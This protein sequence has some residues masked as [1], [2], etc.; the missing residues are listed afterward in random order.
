MGK[1]GLVIQILRDANNFLAR[2]NPLIRITA[3]KSA[4][5]IAVTDQ[6]RDWLSPRDQQKTTIMPAIGIGTSEAPE[7]S[8]HR[9]RPTDPVR[10]LYVGNLLYWKG[11]QLALPAVA[12]VIRQRPDVNITFTV[13]GDGSFRGRLE[14]LA[15]ELD[16]SSRVEFLGKVPR[17]RVL[18]LYASH[19][20]FLFPSLQDSGGVAVVE[21][22][23]SAMPVICLN[24]GGPA[25]SVSSDAGCRVHPT[26]PDE[27]IDGLANSLLGMIDDPER[28][29]RVGTRARERAIT[30][31]GWDRLSPYLDDLYRRVAAHN[32][33]PSVRAPSTSRQRRNAKPNPVVESESNDVAQIG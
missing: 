14:R 3:H 26:T 16:I 1:R 19:D 32:A 9:A 6:T 27:A 12:R 20:L 24:I 2:F 30:L 23:A 18:S 31:I 8:R 7:R 17:E 29:L 22:M 10:L 33:G 11:V 28:C 21:A 15:D 4:S 13:V 25:L 5:I